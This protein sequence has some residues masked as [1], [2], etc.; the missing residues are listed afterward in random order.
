MFPGA[1][2][3][4][5]VYARAYLL[6]RMKSNRAG[7][8]VGVGSLI[9]IFQMKIPVAH[10][11]RIWYNAAMKPLALIAA[12]LLATFVAAVSL[13][14]PVYADLETVTN[15]PFAAAPDAA[16]RLVLS[17]SCLAT[18]S[19]NVEASFGEDADH[20][21]ALALG[22][23][24]F[25]VGWDCGAWFVRQG[26]DS[27][28]FEE[29][30]ASSAAVKT[31]SFTLRHGADGSPRRLSADADGTPAF[32]ARAAPPAWL[33]VRRCSF[34]RLA[35]RGLPAHGETFAVRAAPDAIAIRYR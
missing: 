10:G 14:P 22:E 34:M 28:R 27:V 21:G 17:L 25:T 8:G 5:Y 19:N 6:Y 35:G 31:L 15:V 18:P 20:D 11:R 4:L 24:A 3:S 13:P 2:T 1:G 12:A 29:P 7:V 30:S 9:F 26:C 33:N 32:V 16:G 23:I